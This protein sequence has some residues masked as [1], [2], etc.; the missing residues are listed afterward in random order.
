MAEVVSDPRSKELAH[1]YRPE[2]GM[3]ALESKLAFG[4]LPPLEYSKIL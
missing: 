3:H 4:Q 2:L 1:R